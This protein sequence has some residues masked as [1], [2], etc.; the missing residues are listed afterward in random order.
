[1]AAELNPGRWNFYP[2]LSLLNGYIVWAIENEGR[3]IVEMPVRHGKSELCSIWTPVWYLHHHPDKQ[4][5]LASYEQT[6]ATNKFGRPVRNLVERHKKKLGITLSKDLSGGSEWQTLQG[7]G[8]A[9]VGV[10]GPLTG[11]GV[12]L[13]IID[14]P[15]KNFEEA[16]SK[17][18]REKVFDW[19]TS[20]AATRM[21]PGGAVVLLMARWHV[22]DISGR[23]QSEEYYDPDGDE[24]TVVSMPAI[25]PE[26]RVDMLGREPGEP[27]W[28]ERW[29]LPRLMRAK[30]RSARDWASLYQQSPRRE[31]GN[32]FNREWFEIVDDFPRKAKEIRFWDLAGTENSQG[33]DPDFT[34]GMKV[35]HWKGQY[36]ITDIVRFRGTPGTVRQRIR[37]T[38]QLDGKRVAVWMFQDPGQAGKDQVEDY[39]KNVLPGYALRAYR[40]TGSKETMADPVSAAAEAGNVKILS[41]IGPTKIK[42]FLDEAEDFPLGS[43][44]DQID[45]LGGAFAVTPKNEAGGA[46]ILVGVADN[47]WAV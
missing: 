41:W 40:P 9:T 33:N 38:A 39:Q 24:W 29:P 11:R 7:G 47:R 4:I 34:V 2:H 32:M 17:V 5:V 25:A 31:E 18:H 10:G 30:A 12:D 36:W 46:P 20:T 42:A 13:M 23:L 22:D 15:V 6:W 43:H 45:P 35:A 8:M 26:N 37:Q 27:L 44:D 1:M 14:D 28:P 16:N 19:W 3:L 21:E